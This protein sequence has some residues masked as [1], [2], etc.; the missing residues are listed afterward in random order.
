MIWENLLNTC[1]NIASTFR[2]KTFALSSND[3]LKQ[4]KGIGTKYDLINKE[5]PH[6]QTNVIE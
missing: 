3:L 6:W 1:T 4:S 5:I 2:S